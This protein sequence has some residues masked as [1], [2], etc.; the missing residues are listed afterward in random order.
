MPSGRT[1]TQTH[2]NTNK[3]IAGKS[4]FMKPGA[5]VYMFLVQKEWVRHHKALYCDIA[6]CQ[7]QCA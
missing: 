3:Y 2:I 1:Q 7:Q 6:N 4:S 5:L